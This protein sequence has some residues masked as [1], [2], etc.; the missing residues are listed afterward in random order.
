[1][2]KTGF[3]ERN[4]NIELIKKYFFVNN[5]GDV[6]KNFKKSKNNLKR[7]K[8]QVDLINSGLKDLK[9]EIENMSEEEKKLKIQMK[10]QILLKI[11]LSLIDNNKDKA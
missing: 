11:F 8:T 9:K 5:L 10:Q 4:I 6:L 3:R 1:M 2:R 7:S